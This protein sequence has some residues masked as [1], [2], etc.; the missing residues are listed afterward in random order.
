MRCEGL[1][2]PR[3]AEV[4]RR[5]SL[6]G[7]LR[8]SQWRRLLSCCFP[9]CVFSYGPL[10]PIAVYAQTA[11]ALQPWRHRQLHNQIAHALAR[12]GFRRVP[13]CLALLR[14]SVLDV[15]AVIEPCRPQDRVIE[16]GGLDDCSRIP[17]WVQNA[18]V[19]FA[20][21]LVVNAHR[22]DKYEARY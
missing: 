1:R 7:P 6:T 15:I 14:C 10:S 22:A 12:Y 16:I 17:I 4:A 2:C 5:T 13:E 20:C 18:A 21:N 19:V 3:R 8:H 11:A 9:A